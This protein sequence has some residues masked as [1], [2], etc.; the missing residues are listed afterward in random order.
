LDYNNT[1]KKYDGIFCHSFI[2]LFKKN[3]RENIIK[4]CMENINE[5]GI[6]MVSCCTK[7]HRAYGAGK[8]IEEN[9]FE[10]KDGLILHFYDEEE[11]EYIHD[12]LEPVKIGSLSEEYKFIYGVFKIRK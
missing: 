9:T 12:K 3:E 8:L 7:E 5:N 1:D 2:H 10:I 6:I 11:L 4:K